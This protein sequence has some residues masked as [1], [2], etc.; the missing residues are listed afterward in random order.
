MASFG[1]LLSEI[2]KDRHMTQKDLANILHV[3]VSTIS[4]YEKD[5]HLPDV[6]KLTDIAD[7][8]D[9]TTDYLLSRT[10]SNISPS[11]FQTM[12]LAGRPV[13]D[14]L[15][16]MQTLSYEQ[17]RALLVVLDDM[18]LAATVARNSHYTTEAQSR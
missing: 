6:D 10:D 1:E 12:A 8:F 2:R 14:V 17:Q 7:F 11:V 3:S 16:M 4:N 18:H 15:R 13:R 9:V 5:V